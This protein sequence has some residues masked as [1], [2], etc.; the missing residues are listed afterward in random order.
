MFNVLTFQCSFNIL[1]IGNKAAVST[2]QRT[3]E[4][5][6]D[7]KTQKSDVDIQKKNDLGVQKKNDVDVQNDV[8]ML[9]NEE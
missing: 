7:V 4:K 6:N 1:C 2:T 8:D 3:L 5:Q 9:K